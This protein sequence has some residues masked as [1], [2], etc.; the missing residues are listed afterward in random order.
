M[1]GSLLDNKGTLDKYTG[2]AGIDACTVMPLS[3]EACW[4]MSAEQW[5]WPVWTGSRLCASAPAQ[6]RV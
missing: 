5:Q 4:Q 1:C 2:D 6:W 3:D